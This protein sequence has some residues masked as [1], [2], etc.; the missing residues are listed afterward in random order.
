MTTSTTPGKYTAADIALWRSY[1]AEGMPYR[2]VAEIVGVDRETIARH[3]PGMGWTQQQGRE[4]GTYMKHHNQ[5]MRAVKLAA[6]S[7]SGDKS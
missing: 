5:K 6:P 2:R 1:L 7:M 3:L 4:L